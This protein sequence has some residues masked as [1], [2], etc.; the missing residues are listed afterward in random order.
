MLSVVVSLTVARSVCSPDVLPL[1]SSAGLEHRTHHKGEECSQHQLCCCLRRKASPM[2]GA[3]LWR[4]TCFAA[5]G[6]GSH[7]MC[8]C[9]LIAVGEGGFS[10]RGVSPSKRPMKCHI[11]RERWCPKGSLGRAAAAIRGTYFFPL[12]FSSVTAS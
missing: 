11:P 1:S 8:C 5:K 12:V 4:G 9:C 7:L 6:N 10:A 2:D 3:W